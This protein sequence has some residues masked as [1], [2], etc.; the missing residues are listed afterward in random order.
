MYS[1]FTVVFLLFISCTSEYETA[2]GEDRKSIEEDVPA[3]ECRLPKIDIRH[4]ESPK[5]PEIKRKKMFSGSFDNCKN[6][7]EAKEGKIVLGNGCFK[8]CLYVQGNLEVSGTGT[9]ETV[10]FCSC[11][12]TPGVIEIAEN[13]NVI[14]KN[15]SITGHTRGIFVGNKSSLEIENV[16]IYDVVRGGINVC[17]DSLDCGSEVTVKSSLISNVGKYPSSG[18]SYGIST[19]PGILK[20]KESELSH[21][22]S[23]GI[24]LWGGSGVSR[25]I[26]TELKNTIISEVSSGTKNY[27]GHGIYAEGM[28]D[29]SIDKSIISNC[30]TSFLFVYANGENPHLKLTDLS[31][32]NIIPV[33]KE[34]GGIVLEGKINAAME[35]VRIKNSRGSGIFSKNA[36]IKGKDITIESVFPDGLGEN[37]F[38]MMLFDESTSFFDRIIVTNTGTA[39]VLMDGDNCTAEFEN[40]EISNTRSDPEIFEF[41]VGVAVQDK[42]QIKLKT[43]VL[44]QNRECGVMAVNGK[45]E[46]QNVM[47]SHTLQRE[48]IEKGMCIFA[49]GVPF[50]HGISLYSGSELVF[51]DIYISNNNNG[52]NIEN[53]KVIKKSL[54]GARFVE[55]ISAV[56]AWNI[57]DY[58][59]LE[60]SFSS[61]EFCD[62][63]S[64][65]TTDL[66]PVREKF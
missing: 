54:G 5:E 44:G 13:S 34:Q 64:I 43:G 11:E 66:Q 1:F 49:P 57:K 59:T 46:L 39:G 45:I 61:S 25:M 17:G 56:N 19:G 18:I 28:T 26:Q 23:F 53:S 4:P 10:M 47:V 31:A 2:L 55:N 3:T 15:F 50:G 58:S 42:A 33:S 16:V 27:E 8:G 48:C 38:G 9:E 20:I 24:L 32:E 52:I 12:E 22:S 35:R 60:N 36:V 63:R 29:I 65:F 51:E 37:G 14:L 21:F 40:F 62:N 30:S 41:G 6:I 7:P